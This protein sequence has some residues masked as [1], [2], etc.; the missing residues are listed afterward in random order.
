MPKITA[1]HAEI[2][3]QKED[4]EVV[5]LKPDLDDWYPEGEVLRKLGAATGAGTV[6][7]IVEAVEAK[8]VGNTDCGLVRCRIEKVK[9]ECAQAAVARSW[10]DPI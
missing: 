3:V 7:E 10:D 6:G 1:Y 2:A 9:G 5:L 4:G 8:G